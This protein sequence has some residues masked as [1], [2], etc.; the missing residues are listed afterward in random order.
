MSNRVVGYWGSTHDLCARRG[1][2]LGLLRYI[3]INYEANVYSAHSLRYIPDAAIPKW[4][5]KLSEKPPHVSSISSG[6]EL[7]VP[8]LLASRSSARLLVFLT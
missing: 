2:S 4:S 5:L 8:R 6:L 1:A 3:L 7:V